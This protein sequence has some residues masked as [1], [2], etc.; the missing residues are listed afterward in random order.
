M[1]RLACLVHERNE[2]SEEIP[3]PLEDIAPESQ[4]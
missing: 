1:E 3:N 2:I 4:A